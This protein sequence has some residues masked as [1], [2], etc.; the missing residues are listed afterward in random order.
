MYKSIVLSGNICRSPIAEGVFI[1]TVKD[2]GQADKW[3]ID[4][5]ALGSWHVGNH[6]D[7]RALDVMKKHHVNYS[8]RARQVC[9]VNIL[10]M[11]SF[12]II[13]LTCQL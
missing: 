9:L 1:K 12:R 11:F 13:Q 2:A 3:E 6:P 5:A 7:Y 8:N 4:S 10:G